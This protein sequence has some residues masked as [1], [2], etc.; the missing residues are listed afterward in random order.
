MRMGV[1]AEPTRRITSTTPA[2]PSR[3]FTTHGA[4][5]GDSLPPSAAARA[6]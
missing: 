2:T 5:E 6:E 3:T 4:S 1:S